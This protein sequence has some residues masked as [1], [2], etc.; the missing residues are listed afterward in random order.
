MIASARLVSLSLSLLSL[1]LSLTGLRLPRPQ[2]M[3]AAIDELCEQLCIPP[4]VVDALT[5]GASRKL[6]NSAFARN[7]LCEYMSTYIKVPSEVLSVF[8]EFAAGG[9]GGIRRLAEILV[10]ST[11][12]EEMGDGDEGADENVPYIVR[13]IGDV[14][15]CRATMAR[16]TDDTEYLAAADELVGIIVDALE[17]H[18]TTTV[19]P[20]SRNALSAVVSLAAVE[21]ARTYAHEDESFFDEGDGRANVGNLGRTKYFT[22]TYMTRLKPLIDQLG[23]DER[24]VRV[25]V[26]AR[27]RDTMG[28]INALC[29]VLAA[30]PVENRVSATYARGLMNLSSFGSEEGVEDIANAFKFDPDVAEA[31]V[32]MTSGGGGQI[33]RSESVNRM[34]SKLGAEAKPMRALMAL[35]KN[36]FEDLDAVA[37][38]LGLGVDA[39][40]LRALVA[41]NLEDEALIRKHLPELTADYQIYDESCA[42]DTVLV[43]LGKVAAL[44]QCASRIRRLSRRNE[45]FYVSMTRVFH[46]DDLDTALKGRIDTGNMW[47]ISRSI[48]DQMVE[49]VSID[50]V[51]LLLSLSRMK[52]DA[53][54]ETCEITLVEY[55]EG[56][57]VK[58]KTRIKRMR[59]FLRKLR[60]LRCD[61]VVAGES[62]KEG[63]EKKAG[64]RNDDLRDTLRKLSKF[65]REHHGG[66]MNEFICDFLLRTR[67]GTVPSLSRMKTFCS[68][69]REDACLSPKLLRGLAT[70]ACGSMEALE[71]ELKVFSPA[72]FFAQLWRCKDE[73][74][75]PRIRSGILYI[76]RIAF[77]RPTAFDITVG[78]FNPATLIHLDVKIVKAIAVTIWSGLI[79]EAELEEDARMDES[80][81]APLA[82]V[83]K[84]SVSSMISCLTLCFHRSNVVQTL[85]AT[86]DLSKTL[87]CDKGVAAGFTLIGA[88]VTLQELKSALAPFFSGLKINDDLGAALMYFIRH[89]GEEPHIDSLHTICV[90]GGV[91]E[92]KEQL[93]LVASAVANNEYSFYSSNSR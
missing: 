36:S 41:T 54:A 66:Y 28:T 49:D 58:K 87:G 45:D 18:Q 69:F 30:F 72:S 8:V 60:R 5:R 63:E 80:T 73:S 33:I 34:L 16:P 46:P 55:K 7:T 71:E 24:L 92:D 50:S 88:E 68:C 62:G 91:P 47:A 31:L 6:L 61:R 15:R 9:V 29:E 79:P 90:S 2:I 86:R 84:T 38:D 4:I 40:Y 59:A 35:C 78:D 17:R 67:S 74:K 53:I 23:L 11:G 51:R 81:A 77:R 52:E 76:C 44:R 70:L 10:R 64:E 13:K 37:E 26:C 27:H 20:V 82:S 25:V 48:S 93:V 39:K 75:W 43:A 89:C 83:L 19:F 57:E 65:I 42:A 12:D 3:S 56:K 21:P 22:D 85:G 32:L 14:A 1:F